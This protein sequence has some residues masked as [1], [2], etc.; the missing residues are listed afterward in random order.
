M[1][2]G[3]RLKA[4]VTVDKTKLSGGLAAANIDLRTYVT[5]Q[6]NNLLYDSTAPTPNLI[7]VTSALNNTKPDRAGAVHDLPPPTR[8]A[9][10]SH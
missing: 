8:Q 9:Q 4:N 6:S 3:P 10:A 7:P 1:S 2:T 5:D